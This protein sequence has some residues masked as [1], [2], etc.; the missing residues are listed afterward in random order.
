VT[1]VNKSIIYGNIGHDLELKNNCCR[2][3][4]ATSERY[5]DRQGEK[6]TKTTWHPC[7]IF[8]KSAERFVQY[9]GKGSRVLVEGHLVSSTYTDKNG[10]ERNDYRTSVDRFYTPPR[11]NNSQ[12]YESNGNASSQFEDDDLPF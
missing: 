6:Q 10:I 9:V 5:T 11:S 3:N 7:V 8:G 2:F 4:L 12:G 1:Q